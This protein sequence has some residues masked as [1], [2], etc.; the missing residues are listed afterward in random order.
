[1]AEVEVAKRTFKYNSLT[2]QDP[3]PGMGP[4]EVKA[5]YSSIYP[6]LT[7]AVIEGPE[8]DDLQGMTYEFR[9][10]IGT[11]GG[12]AS[13]KYRLDPG[14]ILRVT[15]SRVPENERL[16][17]LFYYEVRHGDDWGRPVT[18]EKLVLVNFWGTVVAAAPLELKD[19][20]EGETMPDYLDLTPKERRL[21]ISMAT[22]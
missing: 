11:K 19:R 15:E 9:R 6:E 16:P 22:Q 7:Q 2:L 10:A 18:M 1:M 21:L 4:E 20:L 3:D 5:F 13:K 14:D 17:G 12:R 8:Y